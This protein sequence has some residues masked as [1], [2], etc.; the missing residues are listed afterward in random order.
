MGYRIQFVHRPQRF[1]SM[2]FTTRKHK[3]ST[4]VDGLIFSHRN[5]ATQEVPDVRFRRLSL[6]VLGSFI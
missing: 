5:F 2:V 4:F 1:N 3:T 6:E